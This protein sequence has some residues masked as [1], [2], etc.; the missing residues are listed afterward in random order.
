MKIY[1]LSSLE[2]IASKPIDFLGYEIKSII[3]DNKLVV[4]T[5]I[6]LDLSIS[7]YLIN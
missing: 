4:I 7:L 5:T 2:I 3:I 6:S 1:S